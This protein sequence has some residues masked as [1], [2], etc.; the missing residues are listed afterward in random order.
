MVGENPSALGDGERRPSELLREWE[1]MA[2]KVLHRCLNRLEC[3]G[4]V[5]KET[6]AEVPLRVEY[7]LTSQGREFVGLLESAR[8]MSGKWIGTLRKV[9]L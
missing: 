4:L 8:T 2:P 5:G 7:A 1:E 6:F 3:D 9:E